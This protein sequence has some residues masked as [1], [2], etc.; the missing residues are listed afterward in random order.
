MNKVA[1]TWL[2]N[3]SHFGEHS[4]LP[5]TAGS[6]PLSSPVSLEGHEHVA[7]RWFRDRDETRSAP[8]LGVGV[9]S[10]Q[11]V[12]AA[13]E[14][15]TE[16]NRK[17]M[18]IASR[19]QV[20][21]AALSQ[22][23]VEGWTTDSFAKYVRARDPDRRVRLCRDHGG[24]WQHPLEL[25]ERDEAAVM[26]SALASLRTDVDVGFDLLH[27]DTSFDATGEVATEIAARRL[28]SLYE[29]IVAYAEEIGRHVE[30]EIGVEGQKS[31]LGQPANFRSLLGLLLGE[32]DR[33]QLPR[34]RFAVAQT[35][36]SVAETR[37]IGEIVG[38]NRRVNA[39]AGLDALVAVCEE[40]GIA[41]KA[42]NCDY[43][44]ADTWQ[45]LAKSRVAAANVAPE[46]G[47]AQTRAFLKLLKA[48][49]LHTLRARF[50]HLA[51]SS[52][53]WRK[54]LATPTSATPYDC[55]VLAGHYVFSDPEV[56]ALRELVDRS[57]PADHPADE[58]LKEAVK[59]VI[60]RHL[61]QF[62][63]PGQK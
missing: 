53:R 43:L 51:Y 56:V 8:A 46:Y 29:R 55:A 47:V 2:T 54:W 41:L 35:G 45:V 11:I 18:L 16:T 19:R 36:T 17:I 5:V 22:G 40:S 61:K 13:I 58:A 28:L 50:L 26:E 33:R 7:R 32:L 34:P 12:D 59:D 24:P 44:D 10:R 42:H 63:T 37:N 23:Y 6:H 14:L 25:D 49:G 4:R 48:N 31:A 60:R 3:V 38:A 52:G 62:A 39:V 30:F 57:R 9:V 1:S 21:H 20:D 15:A 27:L